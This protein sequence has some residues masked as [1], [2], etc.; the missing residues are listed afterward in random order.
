MVKHVLTVALAGVF[1]ASVG[2]AIPA[3]VVAVFGVL[4]TAERA[5]DRV[6]SARA[7][8]TTK[9]NNAD[10]ESLKQRLDDLVVSLNAK[11]GLRF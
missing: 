8:T 1:A 3:W 11:N 7:Q 10:I 4:L 9:T 6:L 2:G 5:L